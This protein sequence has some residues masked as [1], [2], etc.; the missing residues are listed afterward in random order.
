MTN[1]VPETTEIAI[2]GAGVIGLGIAFFCAEAGFRDIVVL[3]KFDFFGYGSSGRSAGGFRQQFSEPAKIRLA[4]L[5]KTFYDS[6][7]ERFDIPLSF[8][9]EGYLLLA[10]TKSEFEA[11]QRDAVLQKTFNIPVETLSPDEITKRYSYL[12]VDD[13]YGANICL[14]DGYFDPHSILQAYYRESKKRGVQI[15]FGVTVTSI[16]KKETTKD[17]IVRTDR[18]KISSKILVNA[19]GAW[20]GHIAGMVHEKIPV[21]PRRRQIFVSAPFNDIGLTPLI[22][23]NSDPFYFRK[24]GRGFILSIAEIDEIPLSLYDEPPLRWDA[25]DILAERATKRVPI[26]EKLTLSRAWAGMRTITP[27]SL[28]I[29]SQSLIHENL[30]HACGMSG[31]GMCFSPAT[32]TL[33]TSLIISDQ[34]QN[35]LTEN[36]SLKRFY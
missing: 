1:E 10:Q 28:P 35:T 36:F 22:I 21:A 13:L 6:F 23:Q 32:G 34:K 8:K 9:K 15:T 31:H 20:S 33:I 19:A 17:F 26:F 29:I 12:F 3:D 24:E 16:E 11:L 5:S 7:E 25:A 14:D 30:Y 27:D 4:Q 18:G 2:I